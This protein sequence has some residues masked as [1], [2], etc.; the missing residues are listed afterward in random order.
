[1]Y[2][3]QISENGL[4]SFGGEHN[5]LPGKL[6]QDFPYTSGPNREKD[7]ISAIF[8]DLKGEGNTPGATTGIV[9]YNVRL[10]FSRAY[11]DP[12]MWLCMCV[13]VWFANGKCILRNI[14]PKTAKTLTGLGYLC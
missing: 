10:I 4:I 5:V 12:R 9:Y 11:S 8:T 14:V 3:L 7:I 2:V 6:G 13:C 1:M